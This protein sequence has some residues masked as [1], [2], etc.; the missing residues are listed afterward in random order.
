M[1]DDETLIQIEGFRLV[2]NGFG[3][4]RR[5]IDENGLA[6]PIERW[7]LLD[8]KVSQL[9][10]S[11]E[12]PAAG[13]K[14][15]VPGGPWMSLADAHKQL[16]EWPKLLHWILGGAVSPKFDAFYLA[17]FTGNPVKLLYEDG[18]DA[19]GPLREL[20][21]PERSVHS[22]H[23]EYAT[24]QWEKER[25]LFRD[26]WTE[27]FRHPRLKVVVGTNPR[28]LRDEIVAVLRL[29]S[30]E[31]ASTES[32][33][34]QRES[35]DTD[36][37]IVASGTEHSR[38]PNI[39]PKARQDVEWIRKRLISEPDMI[40]ADLYRA[41]ASASGDKYNTVRKRCSEARKAGFWWRTK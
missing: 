8:A 15:V 3:G 35:Q 16:G 26:Q 21:R 32:P 33:V 5:W 40:D 37:S 14:T 24:V 18:S 39:P 10:E 9:K 22:R 23:W 20:L 12:R 6:V 29:V 17:T 41:R 38:S 1:N 19:P 2:H 36:S 11:R 28:V 13:G 34:G 4:N 25:V 30:H 31:T 27:A 7:S